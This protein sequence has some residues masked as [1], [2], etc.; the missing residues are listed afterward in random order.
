MIG[1]SSQSHLQYASDFCKV[2]LVPGRPKS[3]LRSGCPVS[4]SLDILGDRWSLLVIR[5]L[6][7]RGAKHFKDFQESGEGIASNIL[8]DRLRKLQEAGIISAEAG[9]TDG[10]RVDYRLTNKGI[11]LAPLLLELLLWGGQHEEDSMPRSMI[12]K[13]K[14][15]REAILAEVRRRWRERDT[16]PLQANTGEWHLP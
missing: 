13:I 2:S 3:K 10:R 6:M 14:S 8:A 11:D 15:H 7:I 16:T 12:A 1:N 9:E 4:R 5:D